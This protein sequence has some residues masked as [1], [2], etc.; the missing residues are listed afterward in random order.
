MGG[1][2][3]KIL[4]QKIYFWKA[5]KLGFVHLLKST[6]REGLGG[7]IS[8]PSTLL[9][10]GLNVVVVELDFNSLEAF[11]LRNECVQKIYSY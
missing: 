9:I 2:A 5:R 6:G 1:R 10:T 8:P 11:M 7:T 3:W 4:F